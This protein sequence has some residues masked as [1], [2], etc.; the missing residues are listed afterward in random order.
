[1]ATLK[2]VDQEVIAQVA[3]GDVVPEIRQ[4][5]TRKLTGQ[6]VLAWIAINDA[7]LLVRS[8]AAELMTD[9]QALVK[10]AAITGNGA[11]EEE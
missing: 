4:A 10:A 6:D 11:K 5:A 1:M 9:V 2:I 7:T 3:K 8:T